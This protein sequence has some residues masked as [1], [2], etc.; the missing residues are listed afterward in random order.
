ME[1]QR[2][3]HKLAFLKHGP[4]YFHTQGL[5]YGF[6]LWLLCA[7]TYTYGQTI[8]VDTLAFNSTELNIIGFERIRYPIISTGNDTVDAL[9]NADIR[10]RFL[11]QEGQG[12]PIDSALL[13]WVSTGLVS[14]DFEVSYLSQ[15]LVSLQ[16]HTE[17]CGA[18]CSYYT[19]YFN[20]SLSTGYFLSF[21][22][23]VDTA[24]AFK[25]MVLNEQK[26]Q[27]ERARK[28]LRQDFDT[29]SKEDS[30]SILWALEAYAQCPKS[31]KWEDF[32]LHSDYLELIE[33]CELPHAIRCYSLWF[34]LKYEYDVIEEFLKM[35]L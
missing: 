30:S 24:G 22:D 10:N 35:E 19:G 7:N 15:E 29:A 33:T 23:L 26:R 31:I 21:G 6:L 28:H 27:Y 9:I 14:V 1:Q 32:V 17:A 18:Y 11:H 25:A 13:T 4:P 20:Y 2:V 3:F 5:R 34:E 12:L 16:I 8:T